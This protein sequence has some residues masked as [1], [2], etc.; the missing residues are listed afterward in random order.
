[1][2]E[3]YIMLVNLVMIQL[4]LQMLMINIAYYNILNGLSRVQDEEALSKSKYIY[5]LILYH[6]HGSLKKDL[7]KSKK[8]FIEILNGKYYKSES[9]LGLAFNY[10]NEKNYNEFRKYIIQAMSDNG[11]FV[12]KYNLRKAYY[13]DKYGFNKDKSK[14]LELIKIAAKANNKNAKQFCSDNGIKY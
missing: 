2:P 3:N 10:L 5:V 13:L 7:A 4:N 12:A 9:E 11:N 8:L 6:D 1:M 14:E